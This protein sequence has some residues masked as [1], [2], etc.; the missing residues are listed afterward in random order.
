[1]LNLAKR[2]LGKKRDVKDLLAR[3]ENPVDVIAGV[4]KGINE[5]I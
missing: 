1:M 3:L 5:L 4:I 2:L